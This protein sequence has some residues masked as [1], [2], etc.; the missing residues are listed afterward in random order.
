MRN[1]HFH[2][3]KACNILCFG[4]SGIELFLDNFGNVVQIQGINLDNPSTSDEASNGCGK[5]SITDIFSIGLYGRTIKSPTKLKGGQ[6]INIQATKGFVEICWDNCRLVRNFRKSNTGSVASKLQVWESADSIWDIHSEKTKATYAE[7][8]KWLEQKIGLSHHAFCNVVIFDDSGSYSFLEADAPTK[9]Q[10][11]ENLLGLDLYRNSCETTKELLKEQKSNVA[12]LTKE[13]QHFNS[14]L[15][16]CNHRLCTLSRQ[17][18]EWQATK[19]GKLLTLQERVKNKRQLL[20]QIDVNE[21]SAWEKTQ[22]NIGQKVVDNTDLKNKIDKFSEATDQ[23][24][25]KI[26]LMRSEVEQ[27][28][29]LV[30]SLQFS[31]QQIEKEINSQ[32]SLIEKLNGFKEG[33]ECLACYSIIDKKNYAPTLEIAQKQI[34]QCESLLFDK[35]SELAKVRQSLV[36]KKNNLLEMENKVKK[37]QSKIE[38]C[39]RNLQENL[40]VITSL[41]KIPRPDIG[42]K[43]KVLE[44]EITDLQCQ[45]EA[46]QA[47]GSPFKDVIA[48]AEQEVSVKKHQINAKSKDLRDA[49]KEIPYLEFWLEAFG[50]NGIR[51]YVIDGIIPALNSRIAYWLQFLID[52]R[53]EVTFNNKLEER[54]IRNGNDAFYYAMSNGEKRRINL[55]VSQAFAHV[56]VLN[57]GT[58]PNLVFLDEVTGG[59]IDRAGINGIYNMIFELAKD[60]QVFVTTHNENL[61]SMLQG[62]EAIT[63]RK[64]NDVSILSG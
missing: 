27:I 25:I 24:K 2:Y 55:A 23:G 36:D 11:V 42:L 50:D 41:S 48:A 9:R 1:M 5:S 22:T 46:L 51:K 35:I 10:F 26:Q 40:N 44:F 37:V 39:Q 31:S 57:S 45:M 38:E 62:C 61:L 18:S 20:N 12:N 8:Q 14:E 52:S 63:L 3:A 7:T 28:S 64:S 21:L 4:E 33:T 19:D 15:E 13:Y 43:Q 17:E 53:I 6:I 58:C 32:R 47:E 16:S 60:R 30:Q 34:D 49:E 54:I 29:T 59:G 56:M